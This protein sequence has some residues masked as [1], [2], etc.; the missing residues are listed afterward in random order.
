[1]SPVAVVMLRH[2]HSQTMV[3]FGRGEMETSESWGEAEVRVAVY[4]MWWRGSKTKECVKCYV[5]PSSLLL[6][7]NRAK[8]GL[9]K[10]SETSHLFTQ[11]N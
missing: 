2:S 1:M 8:C 5:E 4:L 3:V 9:G 11:Q 10:D 7:Q 6:L